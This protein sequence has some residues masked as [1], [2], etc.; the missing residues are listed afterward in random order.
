[1]LDGLL[2]QEPRRG[3]R[4]PVLDLVRQRVDGVHD[5][6]RLIGPQVTGSQRRRDVLV[7]IQGCREASRAVRLRAGRTR[8]VGPPGGERSH[9]RPSPSPPPTP[10][11]APASPARRAANAPASAAPAHHPH[12]RPT[13][14]TA[15][16]SRPRLSSAR[17]PRATEVTRC[18]SECWTADMDPASAPPPTT[19]DQRRR[20]CGQLPQTRTCGRGGPLLAQRRQVAERAEQAEHPTGDHRGRR[21]DRRREEPEQRGRHGEG[22]GGGHRVDRQHSRPVRRARLAVE[23]RR[24]HRPGGAVHGVRRRY[25]ATSAAGPTIRPIT[26]AP[27]PLRSRAA[28]AVAVYAEPPRAQPRQPATYRRGRPSPPP[29][30]VPSTS[31]PSPGHRGARRDGWG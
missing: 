11:A 25:A 10:A 2:Q 13:S 15:E 12:R 16:P 22:R 18:S 30:P 27:T 14:T 20:A 1:M 17:T 28:M 24:V 19:T 9:R 31:R 7:P 26:T 3:R 21:R 29:R 4:H 5:H 6:P 8:H 23:E